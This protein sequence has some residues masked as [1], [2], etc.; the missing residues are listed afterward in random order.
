MQRLQSSRS[1][2]LCVCRMVC[3]SVI[4]LISFAPPHTQWPVQRASDSP[5][6]KVR[7]LLRHNRSL[8]STAHSKGQYL[9]AITLQ[10]VVPDLGAADGASR[11]LR[12]GA[13][14]VRVRVRI[15][16]RVGAR[17]LGLGLGLG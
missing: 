1:Y 8:N 13:H 14:L 17:G 15:K 9:H 2:D 3:A 7:G 10:L 16:I 4:E 12:R 5:T 11:L 6:I